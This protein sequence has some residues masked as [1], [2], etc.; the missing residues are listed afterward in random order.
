LAIDDD[1]KYLYVSDSQNNRI[2]RF[3]LRWNVSYIP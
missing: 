3:T 1:E 2:Q